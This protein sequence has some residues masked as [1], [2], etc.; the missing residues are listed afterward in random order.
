[1]HTADEHDLGLLH[2]LEVMRNRR[3]AAVRRLNRRAALRVLGAAGAGMVL[4]ACGG[5]RHDEGNAT[6]MTDGESTPTGGAA[7]ASTTE[8]AAAAGSSAQRAPTE[9]AGPFPADGTNGPNVLVDAAVLRSDLTK[10]FGQYSGTASGVPLTVRLKVVRAG[11]GAAYAGAALYL[12]HCDAAGRYSLYSEGAT[13]QNYCRG[14]Q[15]ADGAGAMTFKTVFPGCYAGRWPHFHYEVFPSLSALSAANRQLTSQIALPENACAAV[16]R[17][18][19]A[20]PDSARNLQGVSL[21]TDGV[22][23][24]SYQSQLGAVTGSAPSGYTMTYTVVV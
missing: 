1:M 22:F 8:A 11:S 20:Y 3:L 4:V 9:T 24:D 5:D 21:Q 18:D 13:D 23:R 12:W 10:S 6:E 16:Y 17:D 2:D 14:V 7:S 15:R 19:D